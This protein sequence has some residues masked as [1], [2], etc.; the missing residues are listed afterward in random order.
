MAL[1]VSV[2]QQT[3]ESEQHGESTWQVGWTEV[4]DQRFSLVLDAQHLRG[5]MGHSTEVSIPR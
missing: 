5:H 3:P 4:G 2:T 1:G